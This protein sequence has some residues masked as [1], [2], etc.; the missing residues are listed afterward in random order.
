MNDDVLLEHV[1]VFESFATTFKDMDVL[2]RHAIKKPRPEWSEVRPVA[3]AP[4]DDGD[5]FSPG[6]CEAYC[7][8]EKRGVQVDGLDSDRA[9]AHPVIRCRPDL[10]IRW[11]EDCVGVS[12]AGERQLERPVFDEIAL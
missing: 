1:I 7:E 5:N 3:E 9:E 6:F 11:I 12:L 8:R 2:E 10:P 4:R